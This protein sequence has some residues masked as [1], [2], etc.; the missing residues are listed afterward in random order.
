MI[1]DLPQHILP[2]AIVAPEAQP[3]R[4]RSRSKSRRGTS[5]AALAVGMILI[6]DDG[7]RCQIVGFAADGHPL[8]VPISP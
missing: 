6:M 8:C 3:V 5:R 2:P 1:Y 7:S 4:K